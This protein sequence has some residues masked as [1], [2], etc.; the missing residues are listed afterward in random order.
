LQS[1]NGGLVKD[2]WVPVSGAIAQQRNVDV[3]ANNVANINTPGFKKDQL[4]FKEYLAAMQKGVDDI[5]LPR[6]EWAPGDFYKSY[7]AENGY[8]VV[9][10]SYT[11]HGQGALNPTGNS[12]DFGLQGEGMF[13]ILTP[14]GVRFSRRGTFSID[15][16]GTLVTEL[17]FPVL[18]KTNALPAEEI[19]TGQAVAA[20]TES[21][22]TDAATNAITP[23]MRA[24]KLPPGKIS[25]NQEG[26]LFVDGNQVGELSIIEFKDIYALKKEGSNLYINPETA[27][28]KAAP[29]KTTV[30]QGFVE[31]SNVNAISEMSELIKA[32]RQFESVIRAIKAYDSMSGK[33]VNEIGKF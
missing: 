25:A 20:G 30:Y 31:G 11:I 32:N 22:P 2:I 13:E 26:Q 7:G 28:I 10:G 8:V 16:D 18:A 9:D 15:K 14:N 19:T 33:G 27:N 17:G 4:V 23:E 3:I 1:R 5:D 24:I 29:T 12:L 6:K 21:P